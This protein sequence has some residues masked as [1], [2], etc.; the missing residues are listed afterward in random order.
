MAVLSR[1]HNELERARLQPETGHENHRYP[2]LDEGVN[3][4]K[5]G[6]FF[7]SPGDLM[8]CWAGLAHQKSVVPLIRLRSVTA[9]QTLK[10]E[11]ESQSSGSVRRGDRT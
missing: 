11:T 2:S 1:V 5:T 8:R 4:V 7:T 3:G 10:I 9:S 6:L